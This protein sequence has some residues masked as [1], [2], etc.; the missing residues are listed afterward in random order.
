MALC[1][2]VL[3]DLENIFSYH[4]LNYRV[5][6]NKMLLVSPSLFFFDALLTGDDD[7]V[8]FD[9]FIL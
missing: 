6:N 1:A 2:Y 3:Q 8:L 7:A 9:I 5:N 4:N